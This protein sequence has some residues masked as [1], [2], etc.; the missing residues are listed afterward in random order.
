L[1]NFLINPYVFAG[2]INYYT[3]PRDTS[4]HDFSANNDIYGTRIV[5]ASSV[6]VGFTIASMSAF[7]KKVGTPT[8]DIIFGVFNNDGTTA[9]TLK[10]LDITTLT[11]SSTEYTTD[12]TASP[13]TLTNG[14]CVGCRYVGSGEVRIMSGYS[15]G[16]TPTAFNDGYQSW[17]KW[18]DSDSAW[19]DTDNNLALAGYI[20]D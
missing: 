5:S 11:T 1:S 15:S 7:L 3:A 16:T 2:A 8:G 18:D 17:S 20:N 19:E 12:V 6:L 13:H 4:G 9:K 14:Q 10:T